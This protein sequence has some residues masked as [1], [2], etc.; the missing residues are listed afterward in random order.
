MDFS[1]H[2]LKIFFAYYKP[3]WHLFAADMACAV[4]M[5][6]I[7]VAF[8]M[9]SRY[10]LNT[11]IPNHE[12]R[13]FL[14]LVAVLLAGF[15]IHKG[16]NWFVAYWGHVFGNRV[17]Q[18]MRRDVFDHLEKL[19]F[20]FYDTHRTGKIMSRATTDLF[21][22]TEL[23]H[24]GPEDFTV[25]IL[26]LIGAF[27][28]MLHIRW[29]LAL[30]VIVVLPIMIAIGIVS[31]RNLSKA[32]V[33][34]KETTA[35]VN[36]GLESSISGIRVT[37]GF[38]NEEFERGRFAV[39]NK[40]YSDAKQMRFKYMA[41]F[42]TNIEFC[43]NLLSL[44]VLAVGGYF[45]MKGKMTLPDLVAANLF[46]AG[47]V[48]PVKK[49]NN[50]VE[51]FVTGMAGFNRFLEIMRTEPEPEDAPD[52]VEIL[53]AR[54]NIS[55][56]NVSFSYTSDFPILSGVNLDIRAGEKFA[57]V[58]ASGGGK[59]TICNLIP[60]FY[61]ITGGEISLD[62][63]DIKRIKKSS[64]RAQ[65]GIVQ[66][67]VFLFAGTIRENIAYGKPNATDAE[68]EQAARRAEIHDDIM[69]MPNGYDSVVGERGIKLSGGQ[70]QRVSIARCFLKNPPILILD[71]ATSALDT[72]TEIKIQ[73]SF[74]ELAKGRTT[75]VI[76]HRLS[77]IKNADK[78]AVV[79]DHGIAEQGTHDELMAKQG[80]YYKL[81]TV[82]EE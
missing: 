23:A 33:K 58:G 47:F 43:N 49:L 16:C 40:Q 64:L 39:Y 20:S 75:L 14:T 60:R 80:E 10:A 1:K 12:L 2:P 19:P 61:E 31:R 72:A 44:T 81:R 48:A 50:F 76:A 74:D 66:Q 25:A 79:T 28:M 7:D 69:K 21:E 15:C 54:G 59:S 32:S 11:L 57:L 35:E 3:H 77:T 27:I 4:F 70:K 63:I 18:D 45:I 37:K 24:H 56:K 8:P 41:N 52:A 65:I 67:D 9:F 5:A 13:L 38:N 51:Q 53:S 46:V 68:I 30:V 26:N 42:F 34:V 29:E 22:I 82:Q 78:I 17:E 71:E 36:A 6:A 55:F 73:H 62:G